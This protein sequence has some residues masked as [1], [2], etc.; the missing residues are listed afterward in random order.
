MDLR[1][2]AHRVTTEDLALPYDLEYV[3]ALRPLGRDSVLLR[4]E[5]SRTWPDHG[6]P[7]G[8]CDREE[9]SIVNLKNGAI[10][11]A[12]YRPAEV[13]ARQGNPSK[14]RPTPA[15]SS[16]SRSQKAPVPAPGRERC[17]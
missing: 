11:W 14:P 15:T 16:P 4:A 6:Y 8:P 3:H 13:G 1:D 17:L 10:R 2:P 9:F 7:P 12:D 5:R